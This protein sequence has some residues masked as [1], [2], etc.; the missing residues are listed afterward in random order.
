MS[1]HDCEVNPASLLQR[2]NQQRIDFLS[3]PVYFILSFSASSPQQA[4]F[5]DEEFSSVSAER[6]KIR[7]RKEGD[8]IYE[9]GFGIF[10]GTSTK[11]NIVG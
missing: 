5:E 4:D 11:I 1:D 8:C 9:T 6:I 3:A 7:G 2:S 10:S